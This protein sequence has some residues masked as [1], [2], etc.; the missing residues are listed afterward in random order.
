MNWSK[1]KLKV[2]RWLLGRILADIDDMCGSLSSCYGC[3]N[4]AYEIR[5]IISKIE[6]EKLN[7]RQRN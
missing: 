5:K 7:D 2:K 6:K 3:P 4:E 1:F